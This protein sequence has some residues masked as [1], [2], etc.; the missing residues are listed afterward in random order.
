MMLPAI[1]TPLGQCRESRTGPSGVPTMFPDDIAQWIHG[2]GIQ[3]CHFILASFVS[4]GQH[5][6]VF[7]PLGANTFGRTLI[8]KKVNTKLKSW[9]RKSVRITLVNPQALEVWLLNTP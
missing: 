4:G 2:K 9:R 8:S 3:L 1:G 6:K 5:Y 7:A